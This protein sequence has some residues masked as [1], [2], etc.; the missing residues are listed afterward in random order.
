MCTCVYTHV[1]VWMSVCGGEGGIGVS[2]CRKS[3][4]SK[5]IHT[6]YL[7]LFLWEGW[8]SPFYFIHVF[9]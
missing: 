6:S 4:L 7:G 3:T 9:I 5:G 2:V 1:C 8:A